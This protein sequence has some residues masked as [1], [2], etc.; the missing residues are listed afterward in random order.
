M[1]KNI[2]LTLLFALAAIG[3]VRAQVLRGHVYDAH[4]NQPL[5]GVNVFY[6]SGTGG[7]TITDANGAYELKFPA[8]GG[9]DLVFSYVGYADYPLSVVVNTREQQVK[10]VY[11][12]TSEKLLEEVV[13]T[14]GKFS[15]KM[16]D[17]TVSMDVLKPQAI[18]RQAPTAISATLKTLPGVDVVDKQPSI[19]GG[20]GW[21]YGVGARTLILLDGLSV[22]APQTG[23]AN[24]NNVPLQNVEQV[25]VLKGASSVLYGSSALNGII[26]V[27]T[28]RPRLTPRTRIS[29]Y[30]GIYNSYNND[31]YRYSDQNFWK[32]D[33]YPVTPLLRNSLYKG[34]R[35]PIYEGWD[36]M[37][38]R[39]IGNF[40]VTAGVN[41]LTDEGYREQNYNKRFDA[42]GKVTYHQPV[43]DGKY[44]SY[45][46]GLEFNSNEYGDFLIWRSPAEPLRPSPYTNMGRDENTVRFSPFF[47]Y[48]DTQRGISH[49][50]STYY[51]Y[52]N[53]QI[54]APS[55]DAGIVDILA[56]M[57][58][59]AQ[60]VQKLL[61]GNYQSILNPLV[62]PLLNGG[63]DA[64]LK[65][66]LSDPAL[67]DVVT[68][69][70]T[71]LQTLFP[72]GTTADYNDLIAWTM[73]H[74]LPDNLLP[75][76]LQGKVP[77]DLVEWG[78]AVLDEDRI[79]EEYPA[80]QINNWYVDYQFGKQW[81]G[82]AHITAGFTYNRM[83]FKSGYMEVQHESD[84][85]IRY[86]N[87]SDNASLYLQYDQKFFDRL[88][89]SAGV[90]GEYYRVNDH[91][92]EA[93][94]KVFG[95]H[96][97]FRPVFRA[98]LNYEFAPYSFL[99]ASIGQGYRYPSI[100]EKFI[101]RNIGGASLFPNLDL[102]A[103]SGY[104]A[105]LGFKQGY[106]IGRLS[107]YADVAGFYTEY[108]N[109]IEFNIGFFNS[110]DNTMINSVPDL[111]SLVLNGQSL[112]VGAQFHNVSKAQIYGAEL[113]TNGMYDIN[114]NT[115][116][117]YNL[118]YTFINPIDAD[119]KENNAREDA[120]TDPMQ[121]KS[122][123][124]SSKYLKYRPKHTFKM[125]ADIQWK[126][127]SFGANLN[128]RSKILAVDYLMIDER[129]QDPSKFDLMG[130]VRNLV[131][132][133][134]NGEN[135]ASYW[136]HHNTPKATLDLR[137][138]IKVTNSVAFQF[139]MQNV[140]NNEIMNRP[141]SLE[142]PRT[143]VAK[144]DIDI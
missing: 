45:G 130:V 48:E 138:G 108:R 6:K 92:R 61:Q 49:K 13:V 119:Y 127:I 39:R 52:S 106:K 80:D 63:L 50:V 64:L 118:G 86:N 41:L 7:G 36:F 76:L 5:A 82:G 113:S 53:A 136:Q 69:G 120:Y 84:P 28:A 15:Q 70:L 2:I 67:N 97:P 83:S 134:I 29:S 125:S 88:N 87:S 126:R 1:R 85:S 103:E 62:Q 131:L 98:G 116:L 59:D 66:N 135:M 94:T 37:H 9:Y 18:A 20:G 12:K 27:R 72:K 56:N 35:N 65:G 133:N 105:E 102:K 75:S 40:D 91:Y 81:Q 32:T 93:E 100:T 96:I 33:K 128:W 79:K 58:T 73:R 90:R 114:P 78:A 21:T 137:L 101:V 14:A 19:R 77:S 55:N 51:Y 95:T 22:L 11:L 46:T 74:G 54:L 10:D 57:G 4:D 24:W 122:K 89:V 23:N 31:N 141:M 124:N 99:R 26:N 8:S 71:A 117:Y 129:P 143:F 109:M 110:S 60:E 115:K 43:K 34:I 144:V 38:T 139:Q 111:Y 16:S 44:V 3:A 121:M 104:N 132:G 25:E 68:G 123:S 140:T 142:A 112:A 30:L 17:V 47:N 107:G 42:N